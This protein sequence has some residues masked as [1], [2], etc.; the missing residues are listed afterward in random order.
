MRK[1]VNTCPAL[2]NLHPDKIGQGNAETLTRLRETGAGVVIFTRRLEELTG[3]KH[4]LSSVGRHLS[5]HYREVE[6]DPASLIAADKKLGDL[7][8]LDLVIQRGAA[9]SANWKPSIKDTIEAM[10][11]KLQMTGNSAFDD[12]IAL[13]DGANVDDDGEETAP[14]SP[15]AVA[16]ADEQ[17]SEEDDDLGEVLI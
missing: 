6:E 13:F 17:G 10:K 11:L 3:K 9:N 14:E 8:I 16:D 1:L 12:L 5:K 7:Q 2:C 4:Y 15:E